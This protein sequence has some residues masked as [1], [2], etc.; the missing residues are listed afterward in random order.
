M[1]STARQRWEASIVETLDGIVGVRIAAPIPSSGGG[2]VAE[3]PI[4]LSLSAY[5]AAHTYLE[6]DQG[7][8][9]LRQAAAVL[10]EIHRR[11]L[12]YCNV[13]PET[14]W[15]RFPPPR[16][17]SSMSTSSNVSDTQAIQD[18]SQASVSLSS[19]GYARCTSSDII[20]S[21]TVRLD[22]C[23]DA[24]FMSPEST[25]RTNRPVD[26]RSDIYS[27]GMLVHGALQ[28]EMP[29]SSKSVLQLVYH[30]VVAAPKSL[31][32]IADETD[33]TPA[34]I[35]AAALQRVLDGMTA[36]VPEQRFRTC[37]DV[38]NSL[39]ELTSTEPLTLD[40]RPCLSSDAGDALQLLVTDNKLY[41]R[42]DEIA[43]LRAFQRT[44]HGALEGGVATV[45][46]PSGVGKTTLV[47]EL[48]MPGCEQR[49]LFCGGKFEMLKTDTPYA[50]IIQACSD[51][52]SLLLADDQQSVAIVAHSIQQQLSD[53][54]WLV[55]SVLPNLRHLLQAGSA[56]EYN[57]LHSVAEGDG[58]THS[59]TSSTQFPARVLLRLQ[60]A[61]SAILTIV[62]TYRPLTL[63]LDDVQWADTSSLKLMTE[64]V[65][66][67]VPCRL[68]LVLTYRTDEPGCA[69]KI[70]QLERALAQRRQHNL[71]LCQ[72]SLGNLSRHTIESMLADALG[73][74]TR[75]GNLTTL[76]QLAH[77]QT[78]GNAF[79]V[80]C[81]FKILKETGA[82]HFTTPTD[83]TLNESALQQVLPSDRAVDL[84]EAQLSRLAPLTRLA[85]TT[86]ALLGNTF[87]LHTLCQLLC[88]SEPVAR[89]VL[90]EAKAY[91]FTRNMDAFNPLAEPS[92]TA[93][94]G[95]HSVCSYTELEE[96]LGLAGLR[97]L[98]DIKLGAHGARY[99]LVSA[100][101]AT[102]KAP[103]SGQI[104][105]AV[106]LSH[107]TEPTLLASE[108]YQWT[109]DRLQH[110]AIRLLDGERE[111]AHWTVG[112]WLLNAM[113]RGAKQYIFDVVNLLGAAKSR[114]KDVQDRV[115][116]VKLLIV[117]C[118]EA[119]A[120]CAFNT[121]LEYA[122]QAIEY[123]DDD[124]WQTHYNVAYRAHHNLIN[125]E[126]DNC[127][128]EQMAHLIDATLAHPLSQHDHAMIVQLQVS[129]LVSQCQAQGAIEYGVFD[130]A[131]PELAA[132]GYDIPEQEAELRDIA[133][134]LP[135]DLERIRSL[136][137]GSSQINLRAQ[138]AI[139]LINDL[140]TP[141]WRFAPAL[142]ESLVLLGAAIGIPAGYTDECEILYMCLSTVLQ[143]FVK[144]F[145]VPCAFAQLSMDLTTDRQLVHILCRETLVYTTQAQCWTEPM[146]NA[147]ATMEK[148]LQAGRACLNN[149]YLLPAMGALIDMRIMSG[150]SLGTIALSFVELDGVAREVEQYLNGLYYQSMRAVVNHLAG[151][152]AA[153][154]S[155]YATDDA[156][157]MPPNARNVFQDFMS[158]V[159]ELMLHVVAGDTR[160][161]VRCVKDGQSFQL[162]QFM[163]TIQMA[164][165]EF[166]RGL[167]MARVLLES[168]QRSQHA[169]ELK[170]LQAIVG[171]HKV[172]V[173]R[174]RSFFGCRY[175]LLRGCL[176]WLQGDI[177]AGMSNFDKA[178][179]LACKHGI[180][181]VEALAHETVAQ[182]MVQ[183]LR[184][185]RMAQPHMK[186]AQHAYKRWGAV[187]KAQ[188]L[189][190]LD[191]PNPPPRASRSTTPIAADTVDLDTLH[192]WSV[193]LASPH[194]EKELTATFANLAMMHSGSTEGRL[195]WRKAYLNDSV[196][197]PV[198]VTD[199]ECL[200]TSVA[201]D[202]GGIR[203]VTHQ[204][205]S[206]VANVADIAPLVTYVLR[207][208][209]TLTEKSQVAAHL[210]RHTV[211]TGSLLVMPVL[212][213][214]GCIGV[215][216]LANKNDYGVD[217]SS[218]SSAD[219]DK[220]VVMMR[221]LLAQLVISR[222]NCCLL[223]RLRV[224]NE[225]LQAQTVTLEDR[226]K[227]RTRQLEKV[228]SRLKQ[229]IAACQDAERAA[230][231]AAE[232]NRMFLHHMSHELRTPLNAIIG[233]AQLLLED[234]QLTAEQREMAKTLETSS[235][236]LL[237]IVND[238][239]DLGK[240]QA[241]KMT[242]L[243]Q[244]FSLRTTVEGALDSVAVQALGKGLVLAA[245][246]PGYI[247]QDLVSD[248]TRIGQVLRNLLSNAVKFTETG[249]VVLDVECSAV[250]G[251]LGVFQFTI[252]CV[253]S[254]SGIPPDEMHVLFKE[255]SQVESG[256][257]KK[258]GGTGL[259]LSISKGFAALLSGDLT[260]TSEAGR[261]STFTFT[262][263]SE[264]VL[265]SS[266]PACISPQVCFV[267][268]HPNA[269]L[270]HMIRGYLT[271]DAAAAASSVDLAPADLL[272]FLQ[273]SGDCD[274]SLVY[275]VCPEA[276]PHLPL[277][278]PVVVLGNERPRRTVGSA[279]VR[280]PIR[281]SALLRAA[282]QV[283]PDV[284]IPV[285]ATTPV[286]SARPQYSLRVL[287]AE[288]NLVSRKL[289]SKLLRQFGITA[290]L[291]ED[292][293]KAVHAFDN[294]DYDL[295]LMDIQMPH[296]DGT[297]A[298]AQIRKNLSAASRSQPFIVAVSAN[299]FVQD[300]R[301]Y[302]A[303]GMDDVLPKPI[304]LDDLEALLGRVFPNRAKTSAA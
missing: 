147:V 29:D 168:P 198:T 287:V 277:L 50:A 270:R 97:V 148:G 60:K 14:L 199:M 177:A 25:G 219:V 12:V 183:A 82:V 51:M 193:A 120:K 48:V 41:G 266:P 28:G 75:A 26:A 96:K 9:L 53:N 211:R 62:A 195:F 150:E 210:C 24:R 92:T 200:A 223:Y 13:S 114:L 166:Y 33:M 269:F 227:D 234:V 94:L 172:W 23:G 109:H 215:M 217:A 290:D 43:L 182:F 99:S 205:G 17:S 129:R 178:V 145:Y 209:E 113:L 16:P 243:K 254:G 142:F 201:S 260:C 296:L 202:G 186:A 59:V 88:L 185:P 58:D 220:R 261:G 11:G 250:A 153:V 1:D 70:E 216:Y 237:Q 44:T 160:S 272:P 286:R 159:G 102:A 284:T 64:L 224:K 194:S 19:F 256:R 255:F 241:G 7:I 133:A 230:I 197:D 280:F 132:L 191:P 18:W 301:R 135:T 222:E 127:R 76:A 31:I 233:S 228:N 174:N 265:P 126:H 115:N 144:N 55:L 122:Q 123:V 248:G 239:L 297:E 279:N 73:R 257:T 121:A 111:Q 52:I 246:Y 273:H 212:S 85:M 238:V 281:Q 187:W 207:T 108:R 235:L 112:C 214:G 173:P 225:Q 242:L 304:R 124:M 35:K 83:W 149:E 141:A 264:A 176:L 161:A 140:L 84:L 77:R 90:D 104:D 151:S 229:T 298:T 268:V 302:L 204:P 101:A 192:D 240:I 78:C 80:R 89:Q 30:H 130:L 288:D 71:P 66:D 154:A 163:S 3:D 4:E 236:E 118:S 137:Y 20:S 86:C 263:Q 87:D 36:K 282:A 46:G 226:I 300:R 21:T 22:V 171:A 2:L 293:L 37:Q 45:K 119:R 81:C 218:S 271:F 179:A 61:L 156:F 181:Y 262:F 162:Q 15:L 278:S 249:Q 91:G 295:T 128:Y 32:A 289:A 157:P 110:A 152:R 136:R 221:L 231:K 203:T 274:K 167:T 125:A 98:D 8:I 146:A 138:A 10:D 251:Q 95:P 139:R 244:P 40:Y 106:S 267:I 275:I 158:T 69:D 6:I 42:A 258:T 5:L 276:V 285:A 54:I 253:D 67:A 169:E 252:K 93:R 27:L 39:D 189:D 247:P 103:D 196:R 180:T 143:P 259:G 100:V 68:L 117:A 47:H 232:A 49:G 188:L 245:H 107:H 299:A 283:C 116:Y 131:H 155:S 34:Q 164:N 208:K 65:R 165:F 175:H 213:N 57:A 56:G 190:P 291:A 134:L 63:F 170:A 79:D 105:S 74:D 294:Q 72:V 303:S 206:Q 184:C 292:G 38:I